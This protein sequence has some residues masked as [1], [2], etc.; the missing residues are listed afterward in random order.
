MITV[1]ILERTRE[2]ERWREDTQR[3]GRREEEVRMVDGNLDLVGMCAWLVLCSV[4]R[5]LAR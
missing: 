4:K 2:R 5:D 3:G 1:S